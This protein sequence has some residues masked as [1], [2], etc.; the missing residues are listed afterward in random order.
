MSDNHIKVHN[1]FSFRLKNIIIQSIILL[2]IWLVFSGK[3]DLTHVSLG[4]VAV[5]LVILLNYRV[6]RLNL[7]PERGEPNIPVKI[8]RLPKYILWLIKEIVLANLQVAYI[9][10]H[11]KMPINPKLITFKTK[12]PSAAAKV[13]LGNSITITPGTLTIDIEH[14]QFLVHCLVPESAGSLGNGEMQSR[15]MKLFMDDNKDSVYD[16]KYLDK[17]NMKI[18]SE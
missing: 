8:L 5:V 16:F 9:V 6:S 13:I 4:I 1:K 2:T 15:I 7:F 17:E 14:N 3:Y 12:L 18:E 10:I 11:P